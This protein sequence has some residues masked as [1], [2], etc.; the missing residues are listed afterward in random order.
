MEFSITGI[1]TCRP[2]LNPCRYSPTAGLNI[3]RAITPL[4]RKYQ[5]RR[6]IKPR[7]LFENTLEFER[8]D[9]QGLRQPH[10][11]YINSKAYLKITA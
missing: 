1:W 4:S 7:Q 3:S 11:P 5:E 10:K 6:P 8:W 9:F 2:C